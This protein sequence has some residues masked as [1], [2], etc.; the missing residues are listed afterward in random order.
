MTTKRERRLNRRA[1]PLPC[2][3]IADSRVGDSGTNAGLAFVS[4]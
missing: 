1:A 4:T 2:A 3:G